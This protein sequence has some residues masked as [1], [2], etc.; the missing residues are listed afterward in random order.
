MGLGSSYSRAP[1]VANPVTHSS[2]RSLKHLIPPQSK[3]GGC[4]W[5]SQYSTG[6]IRERQPISRAYTK[7]AVTERMCRRHFRTHKPIKMFVWT[8]CILGEEGP[9]TCLHWP[10]TPVGLLTQRLLERQQKG[11]SMEVGGYFSP[12]FGLQTWKRA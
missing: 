7:S 11:S 1:K 9:Q 10:Q 8:L 4:S 6:G 5:G 2:S 12:S 3:G